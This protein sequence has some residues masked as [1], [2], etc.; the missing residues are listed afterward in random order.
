MKDLLRTVAPLF[1]GCLVPLLSL[2]AAA[3]TPRLKKTEAPATLVPLAMH[4]GGRVLAVN[5]GEEYEYQWPGTYFETAFHGREVYFR[6]GK[7]REILHLV[8]DGQSPLVLT[9]PAPGLYRISGLKDGPHRVR[10]LVVTESQDAPNFFGGFGAIAGEEALPLKKSSRQIEFIGDSHT[11]GYG[12]TSLQRECT[13]EEVWATTDTSQAFGALIAS[14][15]NADDQINAI[16][17]RGIVRNYNGFA[18]DTLPQAYPYVLLDKKQEYH[19]PLWKPQ[20]IVI[21][22]GTN[23]FSTPLNPGEKWK[24]RDELHSDF[25]ATYLRFLKQLRARDPDAFF[26]L[27]AT[28][29]A[30]GEIESEVQKVVQLAQAQGEARIAFLPIDHL[31]F[32]GCNWHPSLAD[33]R[34]IRDKVVQ[35][36]DGHHLWPKE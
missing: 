9:K 21:S 31:Q 1:T 4:I 32:S 18:A 8:V 5:N 26:I 19:D 25:E 3:Q 17:G 7:G 29:M 20:I 36:I 33:D 35:F 6:L 30:H 34:T 12:N 24:T 13:N 15:Y 14:H 11:V 27:W 28:D 16:S 22:L 23:D 2:S 10:V